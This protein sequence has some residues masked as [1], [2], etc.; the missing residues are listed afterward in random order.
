MVKLVLGTEIKVHI[1]LETDQ[2]E[3]FQLSQNSI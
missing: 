3:G 1:Y 2:E